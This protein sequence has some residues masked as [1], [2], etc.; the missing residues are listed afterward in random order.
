MTW[1]NLVLVLAV[2]L[3]ILI[4]SLQ[5]F[6]FKKDDNWQKSAGSYIAIF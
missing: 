5:V 2:N 6:G 1:L 4:F 3:V